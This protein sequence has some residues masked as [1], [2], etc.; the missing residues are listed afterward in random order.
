[1]SA[2]HIQSSSPEE[3][4]RIRQW[5]KQQENRVLAGSRPG[6]QQL[7]ADGCLLLA[8]GSKAAAESFRGAVGLD[9]DRMRICLLVSRQ[10]ATQAALLEATERLA[11]SF[12][13]PSI[14]LRLD[15]QAKRGI[16]M[17][18]NWQPNGEP[19]VMRRNLSRRQTALGRKVREMHA[20]LGIPA[21]YGCLHRLR[22]QAEPAQLASIGR[23]VFEREQFMLP[24]AAE[25]LRKMR[26]KAEAS[27]LGIQPVSAFRSVDYQHRLLQNKLDK[28]QNMTD[29]LRVSAAPG[30]SEHHSGRAV[31]LTTPGFKP[32]EEEFADSPAYAWLDQHAGDFGFRLSYPRGNRHRVAYE[33]WHWYYFRR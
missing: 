33:P 30:Y 24:K 5:L 18:D 8:C 28:G 6:F 4:P 17:P 9:L 7:H 14:S 19:G 26:I 16:R 31:D 12:G 21:N 1:M 29:I 20:S 27:G 11:V 10:S 22:L 15:P 2:L 32:L 25:A 3:L 23:D 13:M